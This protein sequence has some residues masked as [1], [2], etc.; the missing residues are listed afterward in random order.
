MKKFLVFGLIL[1]IAGGAFAQTLT[2][3]GNLQSGLGLRFDNRERIDWNSVRQNPTAPPY[4]WYN[5]WE[6]TG[7]RVPT[8]EAPGAVTGSDAQFVI[9]NTGGFTSRFELSGA[10]ANASETAGVNFGVRFNNIFS[11]AANAFGLHLFNANAWILMGDLRLVAGRGGPGGF[12][13][14]GSFDPSFDLA[15]GHNHL[16]LVYTP[17]VDGLTVGLTFR[18]ADS[19]A[20]NPSVPGFAEGTRPTPTPANT[21]DLK[22]EGMSGALSFSRASYILGAKYAMPDVGNFTFLFQL[23]PQTRLDAGVNAPGDAGNPINLALG[24][25]LRLPVLTDIGFS[26]VGIDAQFLNLNKAGFARP[27]A[28]PTV[29]NGGFYINPFSQIRLSQAIEYRL[30]DMLFG[31]HARQSLRLYD[32]TTGEYARVLDYLTYAPNLRFTAFAQYTMAG[33]TPTMTSLVPRLDLGFVSGAAPS[34]NFRKPGDALSSDIA[35]IDEGHILYEKDYTTSGGR[36]W[37]RDP[38]TLAASGRDYYTAADFNTLMGFAVSLGATA[39]FER[40]LLELGFTLSTDLT[41]YFTRPNSAAGVT[42][43]VSYAPET[44]TRTMIYLNYRVNF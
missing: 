18:P 38:D 39:N 10:A 26:K 13:A 32:K 4:E 12:G 29:D 28:T 33:L 23:A 22:Y 21:A 30:D 1:A 11:D 8:A 17:P 5:E 24:A 34:A 19:G 25:D 3:S 35:V 44:T 37:G 42:D 7:L 14:G 9:Y 40:S 43:G 6:G 15:T 31:L 16:S 41:D 27:L 20:S 36:T 2:W